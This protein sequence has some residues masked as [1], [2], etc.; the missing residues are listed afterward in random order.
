MDAN[1]LTTIYTLDDE[2][3]AEIIKNALQAAGIR[4]ELDGEHQAGFTG[5]MQIGVMVRAVDADRATALL[6][7]HEEMDD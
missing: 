5:M 3:K 2:G 4:C 1:E 6:A 7:E